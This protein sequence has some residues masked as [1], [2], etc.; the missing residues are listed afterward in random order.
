MQVAAEVARE[1]GFTDI[2]GKQPV[3]LTLE[4]A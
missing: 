1:F 2:D 3:A 4:T